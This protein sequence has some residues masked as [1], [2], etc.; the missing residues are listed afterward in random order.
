MKGQSLF[1]VE[2]KK[3]NRINLSSVESALIVLEVKCPLAS[4]HD[5]ISQS[6]FHLENMTSL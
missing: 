4:I 5:R 2:S 1:S 3:K 6:C